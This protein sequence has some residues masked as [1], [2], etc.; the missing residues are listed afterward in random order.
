MEWFCIL[1]VHKRSVSS[2]VAWMV[3]RFGDSMVSLNARVFVLMVGWLVGWLLPSLLGW[4][5][6]G[7]LVGWL[8]SGWLVGWLVGWLM[9][10][11]LVG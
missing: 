1:I 11:W 3:G 4:L 7:W 9:V 5:V 8:V 6:N 10:G 2:L